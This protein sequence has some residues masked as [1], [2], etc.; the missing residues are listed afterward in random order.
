MKF[1]TLQIE[2]LTR[3]YNYIKHIGI[4]FKTKLLAASM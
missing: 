3:L 4:Y 1:I 2:L